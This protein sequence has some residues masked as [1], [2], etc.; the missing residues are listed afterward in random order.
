MLTCKR[1]IYYKFYIKKHK[2]KNNC[3]FLHNIILIY[4]YFP[5]T[6]FLD[7]DITAKH[8]SLKQNI[9]GGGKAT[10]YS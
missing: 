6:L 10:V 2:K 9:T 8:P 4:L 3:I 1:D 7:M 5:V